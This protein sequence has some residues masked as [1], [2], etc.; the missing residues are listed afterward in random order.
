MKTGHHFLMHTLRFALFILIVQNTYAQ[1][2]SNTLFVTRDAHVRGG[3]NSDE[4]YGT[5][6]EMQIK[7]GASNNFLRDAY[8]QFNLNG[9]SSI[10]SARLLVYGYAQ[11]TMNLGAYRTTTTTWRE[12]QIT[13]DNR[14]ARA[15]LAATTRISPTPSWVELDI[16]NLAQDRAGRLLTVALSDPDAISRTIFIASEEQDIG[17]F[18]ARL[19]IEGQSSN[20]R[21]KDIYLVIGQSNAAG[22]GAIENQDRRQLDGVFLLNDAEAWEPARNPMN[23]YS[24]I[25]KRLEL[26]ELGFAYSFAERMHAQ[27]G[28]DIG[29]VVNAR[30]G[31]SIFTWRDGDEEAYF[32]EAY[33]RLLVALSLPNTTFK[34]IL[35]HQGE[36]NR[37]NGSYVRTL[38]D[39]INS[40]RE[41]LN[42]PNMP[43]V[44]GQLSQLREVNENFNKNILTLPELVSNTGVATTE[45]LNAPDLTHFDSQGQRILGRRYADAFLELMGAT[46]R[47][48]T[49]ANELNI[50]G[51][52]TYYIDNELGNDANSGT[53]TSSPWKTLTNINATTFL[54]GAQILFKAGGSW[55]GTIMPKGSGEAGNPIII[56]RYGNGPKPA[57]NGKGNVNCS[58]DP[59]TI[60]FCTIGLSNQEY[61]E[62][63]DLEITNFD[64]SEENG[65]TIAEWENNNITEYA[66]V[67]MP[68]PYDGQN[69]FKYGILVEAND[70]GSVDYLHFNNLE[71]HGVNGKIQNKSNGGIYFNIHNFGDDIPTYYN[72]LLVNN[73][74]IHDVDRTAISNNSPYGQRTLTTSV[75]FTPTLNY[76]ITNTTFE[77]SGANA[78]IMRM[79]DKPLIENCL[80][81]HC[82]IKE[83]GNSAFFFNVDG[84]IMQYNEFRFT[85]ANVGDRDAGGPDIDFRTKNC[86][87]QYNYLHDNDNGL[88]VTGGADPD[89]NRFND[90]P[91]VRYNIIERDGLQPHPSDDK[92]AFKITGNTSNGVIHNNIIFIGEDQSDTR[93]FRSRDRVRGFPTNTSYHNNIIYNLGSNTFHDYD[94][95]INNTMSHNLYFGNSVDLATDETNKSVGN[96]LFVNPGNGPNGYMIQSGSPAIASGIP[97]P[98]IPNMDYYG[99]AIDRNGPITVGIQ[100]FSEG[101]VNS[102][103]PDPSK[104]YYIDN[105]H[106]N[107]RLAADGESEV[108]YTIAT[109]TTNSD[110]EWKFVAK[111][112][113]YWHIQLAKGG[114]KSRLRS[115]NREDADMESATVSGNRTYYAIT[116]GARTGTYFL[117]LPEG[118]VNHRRL[119]VNNS[120]EVKMVS[121]AQDQT[122][123]SFKITEVGSSPQSIRLEA[124]DFDSMSGIQTEASTESGENVGYINDGDWIRFDDVFLRDITNMDARV[125][126]R[127]GGGTLEVRIANPTGT[128]IGSIDIGNTGGFQNWRTVNT[129]ISKING[130]RNVYLVF[131]G[132]N[133]FL[134]NLNW[135]EF[136]T[137][138]RSNKENTPTAISNIVMYPNPATTTTTIQNAANSII[139][140]YDIKGSKVLTQS[141]SSDNETIDLDHLDQGVYYAKVTNERMNSIKKLIKK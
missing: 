81:D 50:T 48:N 76:R 132:G 86:I 13:W 104:K 19:V 137:N 39:L 45:N 128:L 133:G 139:T 21:P 96:P 27:T 120:G 127:T 117:T 102:F 72:D 42:L 136:N 4:N 80:F 134:F 41:K 22:R 66:N 55:S 24:T 119:Q 141:I 98:S 135:I 43:F 101:F 115:K 68:A 77:R 2:D 30:G 11:T 109:N 106:H 95:A 63:N 124:E 62:I 31:T 130:T 58:I 8:L 32:E 73:C 38:E 138:S 18:Q 56:G 75:N 59:D 29:M 49:T 105:P 121:T 92:F 47:V 70:M 9:F 60:L 57:L 52:E 71:I 91:V 36:A 140:I 17:Q 112:N 108:P 5:S 10:K 53:S 113:G 78:V 83:S 61:W 65:K 40:W 131:K 85:K 82:S 28:N 123:V 84:G 69:S 90:N 1:N 122:W 89:S 100:Q 15:G 7:A 46:N 51:S 33:K 54:P 129:N 93:I 110:V 64:A 79:A 44:A 116:D 111:G 26:Q 88:L 34:G 12:N 67:E 74:Y 126:T 6:K 23:A 99:N 3:S 37:K 114:T 97:L 25:R 14:P 107:L 16:T 103:T 118:P 94:L 35:W 125:A 20:A 87:L